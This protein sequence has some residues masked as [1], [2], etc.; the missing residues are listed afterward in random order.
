MKNKAIDAVKM[1]RQIRD[2]MTEKYILDPS[3]EEIDLRRVRRK[4]KLQANKSKV[5]HA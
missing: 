3:Q 1:M 2:A 5:H 4:Y